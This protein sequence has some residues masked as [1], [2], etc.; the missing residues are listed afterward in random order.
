MGTRGSLNT[1]ALTQSQ[2][3]G[4]GGGAKRS[5]K[6]RVVPRTSALIRLNLQENEKALGH[7]ES[8]FSF[9]LEI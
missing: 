1:H 7:L 6:R 5:L 4:K 8:S 3:K 2:G 9:G